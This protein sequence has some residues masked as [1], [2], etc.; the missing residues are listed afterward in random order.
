[1]IDRSSRL[2]TSQ[3]G[4]F[5]RLIVDLELGFGK[6]SEAGG[7]GFEKLLENLAPLFNNNLSRRARLNIRGKKS[8]EDP[9]RLQAIDPNL[10]AYTQWVR[11]GAP[12]GRRVSRS[13]EGTKE[14]QKA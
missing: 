2:A 14:K 8:K 5:S 10:G 3:L 6:G 11:L 13:E 12:T 9:N 7:V 4:N 1:M